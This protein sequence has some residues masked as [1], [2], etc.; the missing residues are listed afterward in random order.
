MNFEQQLQLGAQHLAA[1][2]PIMKRLVDEFGLP[3]F[4]PHQNY[5]QELIESIISQQLS[6]KAAATI[7]GRFIDLFGHF[8]TPDEILRRDF[9]ELKGVG[10]S[11]PK[12]N[13]IRD[14][15][16]RVHDG[17]LSFEN[18]DTMSNEQ[19]IEQLIAVKGVGIWT[20]HMFLIFAMGRLDVLAVGDLGVRNALTALYGDI[21]TYDHVVKDVEIQE[22]ADTRAWHP[23]ES[24]ACWYAWQSLKNTPV[25]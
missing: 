18:L 11:R 25:L 19:I 23:Y 8:P 6:V 17:S 3:T 15:A 14:L 2:D 7:L 20:V 13:Y 5:Y 4:R 21:Y 22:L 9:D 10:L 12:T 16:A 24:L 1:H